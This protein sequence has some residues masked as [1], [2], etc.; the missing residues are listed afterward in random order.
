MNYLAKMTAETSTRYWVNNPTLEEARKALENS[1]HSCT[2]N[3]AH[4]SKILQTDPAYMKKVVR[5]VLE[6][7]VSLELAPE[8]VY[9]RACG[10]L[11]AIFRP[12]FDKTGGREGFVTIQED[13]SREEDAGYI[14]AASMRAKAMGPNYMAKIPVTE[15]GLR[16]I[17]EMVK[18]NIPICATE[19]F[20]ISQAFAVYELYRKAAEKYGNTPP[21]YV[22]HITGIM[23]DY[24][25][26]LVKKEKIGVSPE[27]LALAGTAV[28]LKQ[29]RLF[30]E[31]GV[32]CTMLGGGVR[33]NGHFT[34]FVG[35]D[36]HITINWS[37]AVQLIDQN[38][39]VEKTIDRVIP[40]AVIGELLEK[41]PNF[42][43]AWEE[44]GLPVSEFANYGPVMLFRTQFMNGWSRLYDEV[45]LLSK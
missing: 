16:V 1:V 3:P 33:N 38:L 19:I 13:P 25:A 23:D 8:E 39:P 28:A 11:M 14:I 4:C 34:D 41:L 10:D 32:P 15:P 30:K 2:T 44:D 35:G 26:D 12:H 40:E 31:R 22:T 27:A 45:R 5:G 24:F 37:T 9:H 17:D 20:S 43:R 6:S 29:Y 21:M 42:R 18:H 7:G 36:M